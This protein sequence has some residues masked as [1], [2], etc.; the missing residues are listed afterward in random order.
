MERKTNKCTFL[1]KDIVFGTYFLGEFTEITGKPFQEAIQDLQ[2]NP[3]KFIPV[4]LQT[5]I[6][7]TAEIYGGEKVELK[8]VLAEID[9]KGLNSKEVQNALDTFTKSIQVMAGTETTK[10]TSAKKK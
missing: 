6:N 10:K 2:K 5:A 4:F 3:F 9:N 7:T 8:E 1:G